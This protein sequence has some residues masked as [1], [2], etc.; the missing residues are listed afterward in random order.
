MNFDEL[1]KVLW[2]HN[3]LNKKLSRYQHKHL[4]AGEELICLLSLII[5]YFL[6]ALI[7]FLQNNVQSNTFLFKAPGVP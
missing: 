2:Q 5:I 7:A 3:S 4:S 1:Q 6:T